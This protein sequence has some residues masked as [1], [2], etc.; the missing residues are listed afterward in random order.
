MGTRCNIIV[1]GNRKQNIL[2]RHWDGYPRVT[3]RELER[4]LSLY[5]NEWDID[6]LAHQLAEKGIAEFDNTM[7]GDIEYLYE[8]DVETHRLECYHLDLCTGDYTKEDL[9]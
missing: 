1:K 6:V 7:H 8:I 3:G 5:S 4:F 9:L 2:Y